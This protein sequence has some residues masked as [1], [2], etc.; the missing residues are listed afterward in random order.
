MIS[1]YL[2]SSREMFMGLDEFMKA[3]VIPS[4][5]ETERRI[6]MYEW[7]M[8]ITTGAEYVKNLGYYMHY[9]ERAGI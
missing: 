4:M 7:A 1:G 6:L 2:G 9:R 3:H 5:T 8:L